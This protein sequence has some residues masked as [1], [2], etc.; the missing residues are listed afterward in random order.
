[1]RGYGLDFTI[2]DE[3]FATLRMKATV[4]IITGVGNYYGVRIN[5]INVTADGNGKT[6]IKIII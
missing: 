3:P 1:M 5:D 2:L 6:K 4:D